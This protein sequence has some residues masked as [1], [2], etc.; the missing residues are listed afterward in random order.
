MP[1]HSEYLIDE[2]DFVACHKPAY[3]TMYDMISSIKEG[4]TFLLNCK[5]SDKELD[6]ELPAT[7]KNLLAKKKI[8]M[9]A[10]DALDVATK[11]GSPK[12]Q[13]WSFRRRSSR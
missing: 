8:K 4:G 3:V 1:I 7:M 5:W 6:S 9:Y 2:A 12:S 10:I 13:K 11:A